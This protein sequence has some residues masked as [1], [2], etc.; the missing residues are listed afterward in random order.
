MTTALSVVGPV[1]P[2]ARSGTAACDAAPWRNP[3][4]FLGAPAM[5]SSV[6]LLFQRNALSSFVECQA[7]CIY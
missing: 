6:C 1:L 7:L 5:P 3:P 4:R 2:C